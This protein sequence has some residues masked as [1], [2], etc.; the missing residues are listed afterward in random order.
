M[1]MEEFEQI[2]SNHNDFEKE[3]DRECL[4]E[5]GLEAIGI[6]GLQDPLRPTIVKSI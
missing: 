4:E 3:G 2:K 1:T 6:F 5:N